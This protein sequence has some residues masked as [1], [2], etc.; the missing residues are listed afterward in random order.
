[1]DAS[2]PGK[3]PSVTSPEFPRAAGTTASAWP[4]P[5]PSTPT[6]S[7]TSPRTSA[8]ST[9]RRRRRSRPARTARPRSS[10]PR[11]TTAPT[12]CRYAA[13]TARASRARS[14][15]TC[16]TSTGARAPDGHW[17]LDEGQG[18]VA[19][20]R[21]RPPRHPVRP[22]HLDDRQDRT[23]VAARERRHAQTSGPAVDTGRNFTVTAWARLTGHDATATVVTQDG[24]ADRRLLP[25]VLQG[26]RPL[27]AEPY[28]LRR[29]RRARACARCRRPRRG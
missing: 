11:V 19:A 22:G 16:S 10:S 2:A 24:A 29:R 28:R 14:A 6:A 17:S 5:S 20:D 12:C 21:R 4:A 18:T 3:E 13:R 23:G 7:P 15:P 25:A 27:G 9:P 8:G 26:R 1:M